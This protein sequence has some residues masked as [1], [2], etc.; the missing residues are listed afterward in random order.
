MNL[1][2]PN[3]LHQFLPIH[4]NSA[5]Q[6]SNLHYSSLY[7]Q[8]Q[9]LE[10]PLTNSKEDILINTN[11]LWFENSNWWKTWLCTC[12]RCH[13]LENI[14]SMDVTAFPRDPKI[15]WSMLVTENHLMDQI[16]LADTTWYDSNIFC[17]IMI[18][19][20]IR[21]ATV[22]PSVIMVKKN[23]LLQTDTDSLLRKMLSLESDG[24]NVWTMKAHAN[25]PCVNA[26][27]H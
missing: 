26:T 6:N 9:V 24:L 4:S 25:A 14:V 12:R 11:R 16:T 20:C 21:T 7:L 2:R 3:I 19:I 17:W 18:H 22:V 13:S 8:L 5:N 27:K 15:F 23:A 1:N 10:T